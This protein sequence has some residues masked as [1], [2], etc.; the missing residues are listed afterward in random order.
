M[1]S[2][3]HEA[4]CR[5]I[6]M[7]ADHGKKNGRKDLEWFREEAERISVPADM[8]T[9]IDRRTRNAERRTVMK[10]FSRKKAVLI[11]AAVA[12]IG[13][14]TAA[15][16]GRV[17][18][19][20]SHSNRNDQVTDYAAI[21]GVEEKVGFAFPSLEEFSNSF[22]FAY[23][24]PGENSDYDEDGNVLSSYQSV[25]LTYTDGA[26]GDHLPDLPHPSL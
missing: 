7:E 6:G 9:E 10:K 20:K 1:R 4:G 5:S 16:A 21:A 8:K 3:A 19:M 26:S 2:T 22:R 23:A 11:A 24:L 14:V 18:S 25:D 17:A 12:L 15:A 13:S